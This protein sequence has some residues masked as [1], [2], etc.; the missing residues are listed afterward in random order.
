MARRSSNRPKLRQSEKVTK[1]D[2]INKYPSAEQDVSEQWKSIVTEI[3]DWSVENNR[4]AWQ[5]EGLIGK[6]AKRFPY[7]KEQSYRRKI[8]DMI[9]F[10]FRQYKPDYYLTSQWD[11]YRDKLPYLFS[12]NPKES[13]KTKCFHDKI[14]EQL[15]KPVHK[16]EHLNSDFE[17]L[18]AI[19]NNP[20]TSGGETYV[21]EKLECSREEMLAILNQGLKFSSIYVK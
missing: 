12:D 10:N 13:A 11:K 4:Y 2:V 9:T 18:D 19:F 20:N 14:R 8:S 5:L 16:Q 6:I 7:V 17:G 15:G 21:F 3:L 1:A